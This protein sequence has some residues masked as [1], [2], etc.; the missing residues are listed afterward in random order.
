[1]DDRARKIKTEC[2]LEDGTIHTWNYSHICI[3]F[4]NQRG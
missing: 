3:M 1:M 2:V 4:G